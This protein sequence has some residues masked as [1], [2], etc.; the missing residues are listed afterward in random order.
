MARAEE[1]IHKIDDKECINMMHE[2]LEI[3]C[4]CWCLSI[5]IYAWQSVGLELMGGGEIPL[6]T[7]LL[8]TRE[9]YTA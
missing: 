9:Y 1:V 2:S 8:I 6:S 7:K 3:C 4:C 5:I